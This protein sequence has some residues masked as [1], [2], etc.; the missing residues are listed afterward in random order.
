[1]EDLFGRDEYEIFSN[2]PTENAKAIAYLKFT[3]D[4]VKEFQE[5]F[6]T[7]LTGGSLKKTKGGEAGFVL[8]NDSFGIIS[9]TET[10]MSIEESIEELN[11]SLKS[12]YGWLPY[13]YGSSMRN[14]EFGFK[15]EIRKIG[16]RE[17]TVIYFKSDVSKQTPICIWREG[18]VTKTLIT[19]GYPTYGIVE[20]YAG[21]LEQ[22]ANNGAESPLIGYALKTLSEMPPKQYDKKFEGTCDVVLEKE[23]DTSKVKEFFK[24]A[25]DIKK[26]I[27]VSGK[28]FG[29]LKLSANLGKEFSSWNGSVY[30]TLFGNDNADNLVF[31][32]KANSSDYNLCYSSGYGN[33]K[34]EIIG[35]DGKKA[36]LKTGSS[37]FLTINLRFVTL[38]RKVGDYAIT[39]FSYVKE[40]KDVSIEEA[41]N[42]IFSVNLPGEEQNWTDKMSFKVRVYEMPTGSLKQQPVAEAK[43]DVYNQSYTYEDG[44]SKRKLIKTAYT[45]DNGIAKFENLEIGSYNVETSKAGYLKDTEYVY[46]GRTDVSV[47]LRQIEPLVV[48]VKESSG[49][50]YGY[51]T[52]ISEAKVELY[53]GSAYGYEYDYGYTLLKTKYTD[54][55][56][57]V[58]FGK[59]NI[60]SGKVKV[61][62]EGYYNDTEYVSTYSK[63]IIVYLTP[64]QKG[65]LRVY[66]DE[67]AEGHPYP[68]Y[69]ALAGAKIELY[70]KSGS[71]YTLVKTLY[72]NS[73]G[74]A[75][76]GYVDIEGGKIEASKDGYYNSTE[77]IRRGMITF[78]TTFAVR[79]VKVVGNASANYPIIQ[80]AGSGCMTPSKDQAP[81]EWVIGSPDGKRA[82]FWETRPIVGRFDKTITVS[83]FN[84]TVAAN[85]VS[86][87]R[88]LEVLISNDANCYYDALEENFTSYT[89]Y[90]TF[91]P[92][93]ASELKEYVVSN[94]TVNARC[95]AVKDMTNDVNGYYIDAIGVK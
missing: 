20:P 9:Y 18:G 43:V 37:G 73:G 57:V 82:C 5:V 29:E 78:V 85:S 17:I 79:L 76:F 47:M 49:Y 48:N 45:D 80:A 1:L 55:N 71:E 27:P 62:K 53:N 84:L 50:R 39:L 60:E 89:H 95:I 92:D 26:S 19:F 58:D 30:G 13:S 8:Y 25:E 88:P 16:E 54:V 74:I 87:N 44:V 90:A 63:N 51:G 67:V 24:D 7:L 12:L 94:G 69:P 59:V 56:G 35:R 83:K 28:L 52:P 2:L 77:I 75:D 41:K 33:E 31:V 68:N 93:V 11:S 6:G 36:C 46:A 23:Y 40:N 72:T 66:V 61:S 34:S 64:T 14:E 10:D 86:V 4:G 91:T 21:S 65:T 70:N 3:E 81:P 42:I 22:P 15:V 32:L 38:E